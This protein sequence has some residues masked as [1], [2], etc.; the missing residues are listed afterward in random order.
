MSLSR[1]LWPRPLTRLLVPLAVLGPVVALAA[2]PA[3]AGY[4]PPPVTA[5][6]TSANPVNYTPQARNGSVRAFAQIGDTIYAGGSFTAIKAAG[7]TVWTPASYLVAYDAGTGALRTAFTPV[8][9]NA[10][11]ALA[12]SPDGKLIVGG[13][14]GKVNGV[15]RR[16]LVEI[17][18]ATGDTITSWAGRADGGVVRRTVVDGN[19]L[20]V[21]GAFHFV[22]GT[23]HHLLARLDATTGAIDSTFQID[24]SGARPYPNSVELVWAIAVSPDGRTLMATGNFTKVNGLARNQ[25]VMVDVSGT[26]TVANWTTDRYVAAC[27]SKRF[28]FYAR[29]V[30]FSDDGTYF[31]VGADGGNGQAYC[32]AVAR[33]E[34]SD[35]GA[36]TAT[37]VDFTGRDSTTSI[38]AADGV[39]YVAGHFR[40]MNNANGHDSK[41]AGGVDRRAHEPLAGQQPAGRR[42][43][44]GSDRLGAVAG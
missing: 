43:E 24:A 31:V 12:V 29:D 11:Q 36:V 17:D 28:P 22:N 3:Q 10:V 21:S 14:F 13:N 40:W 33:F 6:L 42:R 41:G 34:T 32:D 20:Y 25:V 38:E 23:A 39:I 44:V 4:V 18:P 30:D 37:W 26:P 9:D 16:N 2:V 8:F 15:A 5:T 27:L 35:R 1:R 7:S 19:H